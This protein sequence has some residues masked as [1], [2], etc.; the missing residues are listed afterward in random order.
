M[1]HNLPFRGLDLFASQDNGQNKKISSSV[2]ILS[3]IFL[4]FESS[5]TMNSIVMIFCK[6]LR[7][8]KFYLWRIKAT[9]K[10]QL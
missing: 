5:E 2:T 3:P 1:D 8:N 7:I 9:F 6:K 10:G 4:I